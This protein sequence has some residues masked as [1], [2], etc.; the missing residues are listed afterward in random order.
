MYPRI[1]DLR[2][3]ASCLPTPT[4]S[5][6]SFA[7]SYGTGFAC[8]TATLSHALLYFRA[9]IR[10]AFQ[11]ARTEPPDVHARLMA[12]YPQ[13]PGWWYVTVFCFCF[14]AACACIELWEYHMEVWALVIALA[15]AVVYVI[16]V[17]E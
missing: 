13:V 9:P 7:V 5:S 14:A 1:R 16:P 6:A 12:S 4:D 8:V 17:G 3:H 11:R 15:I 2:I 10:A